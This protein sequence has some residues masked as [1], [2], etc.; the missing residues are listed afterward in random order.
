MM[1]HRWIRVNVRAQHR[2]HGL[3]QGL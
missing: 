2:R 3:A 1:W